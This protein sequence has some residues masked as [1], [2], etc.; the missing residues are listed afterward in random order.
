MTAAVERQSRGANAND[1]F[2]E[3]LKASYDNDTF[4]A[5]NDDNDVYTIK[6]RNRSQ[7]K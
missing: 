2:Q 5:Y 3:L 7:S 4:A 1:A 6:M